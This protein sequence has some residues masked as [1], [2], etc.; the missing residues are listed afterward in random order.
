MVGDVR[1][2]NKRILREAHKRSAP[3]SE[4]PAASDGRVRVDLSHEVED[5]MTTHPG[6][7]GSRIGEQL[8]R[9]ASRSRY[10]PGTEFQ[11][12]EIT[13]V[14]NTGTY[15]DSPFHRHPDGDE[16]TRPA[17]SILLAAGIPVCENLTNHSSRRRAPGS[18]PRPSRSA[19]WGRS[20]CARTRAG[21]AKG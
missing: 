5:G 7:P 17:H 12:G 14:A 10:A 6:L 8:S 18:A 11:I 4:Q 3:A 15:V 16:L 20:P 19:A 1:I 13:M 9:A 2:L 21:I